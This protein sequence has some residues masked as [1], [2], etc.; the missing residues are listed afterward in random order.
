MGRPSH[1]REL[2]VWTNGQRVGLWTFN[3][4][5]EHAFEYDPTWMAEASARPLSLSLPFT[6]AQSIRGD[7]V[8]SFFDNL[9]PDSDAIRLR[10]AN[11]FKTGSAETFDLLQ[12]IGRDC[13]GAVQLLASDET[14]KSVQSIMGT[15]LSEADI[16]ALLI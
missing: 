15:P 6:G 12:A 9:L 5:A 8:S 14:P 1:T 10:L 13:V 4:R 7:R 2:S 11:R 3:R 16:E